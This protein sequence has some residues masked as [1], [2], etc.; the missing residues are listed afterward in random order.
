MYILTIALLALILLPL[1]AI[2]ACE[3]EVWL[4]DRRVRSERAKQIASWGTPRVV[5]QLTRTEKEAIGLCTPR[6]VI[7]APTSVTIQ[8][9][10]SPEPPQASWQKSASAFFAAIPTFV[11][12]GI[13]SW[14][15]RALAEPAAATV[16]PVEAFEARLLA[17]RENYTCEY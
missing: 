2:V 15:S 16:S 6:P 14:Q 10:Y 12:G 5:V 3:V 11:E 8:G 9:D 1:A 17:A 4:W 7:E 13:P